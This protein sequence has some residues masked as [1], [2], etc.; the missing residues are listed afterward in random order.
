MSNLLLR[1]DG[2]A[3]RMIHGI[4]L[5]FDSYPHG[6]RALLGRAKGANCRHAYGLQFMRITRQTCCAYYDMDFAGDYKTWLQMAL[7][8]VVP[9]KAGLAK[10]ITAQWLDDCRSTV[11]ARAACNTFQNRFELNEGELYPTTSDEYFDLSD[12]V[13]ISRAEK[14]SRSHEQ[15]RLS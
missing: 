6:G 12:R 10:G 14:V 4:A 7:D 8:H 3:T 5:P 9:T 13:F 15:E 11:L 2:M 1:L